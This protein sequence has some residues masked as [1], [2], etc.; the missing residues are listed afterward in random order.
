MTGEKFEASG[1]YKPQQTL[2][3]P[4][5]QVNVSPHCK[6]YLPQFLFINTTCPVFGENLQGMPKEKNTDWRDKGSIRTIFRYD[7]DGRIIRQET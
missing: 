3:N 2:N 7:T 6:A 1:S 4:N 5:S